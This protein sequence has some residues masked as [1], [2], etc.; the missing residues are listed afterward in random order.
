M[1]NHEVEGNMGISAFYFYTF[2]EKRVVSRPLQLGCM[3][4]HTGGR[5]IELML[6]PPCITLTMVCSGWWW[7]VKFSPHMA[8]CMQSF[9]SLT[10]A[11][12]VEC[13]MLSMPGPFGI[14]QN[15]DLWHVQVFVLKYLWNSFLLGV[16]YWLCSNHVFLQKMHWCHLLHGLHYCYLLICGLGSNRWVGTSHW[17][18]VLNSCWYSHFKQIL[19]QMVFMRFVEL[20]WNE[21]SW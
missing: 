21:T 20:S 3:L 16:L 1:Y 17:T 13:L 8:F 14:D 15:S 9:H 4:G 2:F 12:F 11:I 6:S 10:R 19:L 18:L 7:S 5:W